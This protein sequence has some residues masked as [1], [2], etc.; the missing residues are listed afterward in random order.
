[1]SDKAKE[2][3]VSILIIIFGGVL[4]YLAFYLG[5]FLGVN[6][7]KNE[8]N[9]GINIVDKDPLKSGHTDITDNIDIREKLTSIVDVPVS[10]T[11]LLRNE[12]VSDLVP[13]TKLYI[14]IDKLLNNNEYKCGVDACL[15][16][17][18]INLEIN[19]IFGS[20][21][22]VEAKEYMEFKDYKFNGK[23]LSFN[24]EKNMYVIK[25]Y[26]NSIKEESGY[27]KVPYR[28]TS[29]GDNYEL[30]YYLVYKE[31]DA[32]DNTK[33]S[34]YTSEKKNELIFKLNSDNLDSESTKI[35]NSAI[36]DNFKI[37]RLMFSKNNNSYI[38][39]EVEKRY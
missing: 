2:N 23:T 7:I 9:D 10:I 29:Y 16:V 3:I 6:S 1:M 32:K 15:K 14:G 35:V 30:S 37:V 11:P 31:I 8:R 25:D 34:Y 4:I 13:F 19:N 5:Q 27:I 17:D 38:V 20:E 28:L 22:K 12:L 21:V 39:S 24:K 26:Y 36:K 18:D 33:Y